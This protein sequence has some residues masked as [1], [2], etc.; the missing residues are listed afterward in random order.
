VAGSSDWTPWLAPF[1]GALGGGARALDITAAGRADP[2]AQAERQRRRLAVLVAHARSHSR[3]YRDLY[4]GLPDD[5]DDPSALPWVNKPQLMAAFDDWVTDPA[6]SLEGVKSFLA[7]RERTGELYGGRFAVWRS[8]GTSGELGIFVHDPEALALYDLL[9]AMRAWAAV[10]WAAATFGFWAAGG[11]M[12]C[13]TASEDHFAGISSWRRLARTYPALGMVMRDF[14]VLMPL[15]RLVA[16]LNAWRPAQ[17][18]AYPS[19]LALLAKEREAGRLDVAPVALFAGG[20]CLDE[21]EH[22]LIERAFGC[23]L[24]GVYA[25]AECDYVAFGCA[26]RNLHVNADWIVVEPVDADHRPVPPGVAS[27][28]ALVTNLAN[29]VQPII[30][31]DLGDSVT[32]LPGPC[33]CGNPLPAIR[34]EGRRDQLLRFRGAAGGEVVVLPMA[35]TTV[36]ELLDGL[37]RFQIVQEDCARLRVACE[38]SEGA[39]PALLEGRIRAALDAFLAEQGLGHIAVTVVAAPLS[40]DPVSGKFH[41]VISALPRQGGS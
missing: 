41:Q 8:S 32:V 2:A 26:H 6:V 34:V 16:A 36:L 27:H 37:R 22:D 24:R 29:R 13:L 10:P 38:F 39:D 5:A 35:I 19:A 7:D 3:L 1:L 33:P 14:S 30:R 31:Y 11:R 12:A 28:S 40:T 20:E 17:I 4:R 23:T 25:C 18:V 21:G 15:D 9:F